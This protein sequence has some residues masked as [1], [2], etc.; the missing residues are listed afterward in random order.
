MEAP[1]ELI[2]IIQYDTGGIKQLYFHNPQTDIIYILKNLSYYNR[3]KMFGSFRN[4]Y[5][6]ED[7]L[8]SCGKKSDLPSD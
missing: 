4:I 2:A 3:L 8:I 7:D 6:D 5:V 1:T